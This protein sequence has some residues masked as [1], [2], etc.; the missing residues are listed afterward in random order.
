MSIFSRKRPRKPE[1]MRVGGRVLDVLWECCNTCWSHEA[2]GRPTMTEIRGI[3]EVSEHRVI[4]HNRCAKD[5][6]M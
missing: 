1:T 3:V 4:S 2:P 6:A 5:N